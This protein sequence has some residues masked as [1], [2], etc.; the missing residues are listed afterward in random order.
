MRIGVLGTG[1]V[2]RT[3]GSALV[4]AGHDVTMGSRTT[5]NATA[6]AWVAQQSG[7]SGTAASSDFAGAAGTAELVVNATAGAV[8]LAALSAAG[9]QN[10]AGKPL[11]DVAN[12]LDFSAGFPP[13][14]SICNDDSL[15]ETIQRAFPQ[16]RV[17]K[18]LNTVNCAVMVDPGRVPGRHCIFVAGNDSTAKDTVTGLLAQFGWPQGSVIDLGDISAARATEMYLP[19]WLRLM[20]A[21]GSPD[22][23]LNVVRPAPQP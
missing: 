12:P 22:F 18:S 13:K 9:A 6:A 23:N 11:L 7:H 10:L 2:G 8:S 20:T 4:M 21:L 17:V 15:G 3:L 14:L 16:A 5:D 1:V 19:L